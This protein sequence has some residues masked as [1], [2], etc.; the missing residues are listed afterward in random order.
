MAHCLIMPWLENRNI[1][2]WSVEREINSSFTAWALENN[3]DLRSVYKIQSKC[4]CDSLSITLQKR[5][6]RSSKGLF[7]NLPVSIRKGATSQQNLANAARCLKSKIILRYCSTSYTE[8]NWHCYWSCTRDQ[9]YC[10][11]C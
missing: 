9:V 4:A 10:L 1:N 11:H 7:S 6:L 3:S 5:H 2:L 8:L